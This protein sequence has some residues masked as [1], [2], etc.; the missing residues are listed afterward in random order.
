MVLILYKIQL[1]LKHVRKIV[2]SYQALIGLI[3]LF[4]L[5][6]RLIPIDG[7][8]PLGFLFINNKTS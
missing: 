7:F 6:Y 2:S 3:D 1:H 4:I 5:F 8:K